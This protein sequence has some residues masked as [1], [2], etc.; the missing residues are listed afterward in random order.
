MRYKS[1]G[2]T[3]LK[4]SALGVGTWAMGGRGWGGGDRVES[5][6]ALRAMVDLGVNHVDTAP[7]YGRGLAEEIV[8]EAIKGIR[9]DLIVT[10]KCGMNIDKPG[11]AVK[12]AA[13][14]EILRGCEGSLTRM[15]LDY[16]DILL[17]HWPDVNTPLQETMEAMDCLKKQGKIRFI[18]V[19][20]LSVEQMEEASKYADVAVTQLPFSMVDRSAGAIIQWAH[21]SGMA[22]MT[23]GSLGAGILTGNIREYKEFGEGDVRGGFYGFFR[24]PRFS[25]IMTLLKG[26]DKIAE[27]RGVTAAQVALNWAVQTEYVDT[28]LVGVTKAKHAKENCQAMEWE[29]TDEEMLFLNEEIK[30]SLGSK[31]L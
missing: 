30:N 2:Q 19:S 22:T 18:G 3:G 28:A 24:E 16:I 23:Y 7:A 9:G 25:K 1:F 4:I 31:G 10:T 15:K 14:D 27:N 11:M 8:G 5:I 13:W 20:N 12:T 6:S 17:L 26:M 29:L 21:G